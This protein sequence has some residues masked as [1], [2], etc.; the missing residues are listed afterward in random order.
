MSGEIEAVIGITK[1]T[2]ANPIENDG[3]PVFFC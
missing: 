3:I 2:G 1:K